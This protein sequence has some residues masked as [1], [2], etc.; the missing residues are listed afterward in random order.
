MPSIGRI[1]G[2]AF[3][4]TPRET[5]VLRRREAGESVEAIAVALRNSVFQVKQ[6]EAR[7]REKR[8][9]QDDTQV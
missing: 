4:L 8:A 1:V 9:C 2:S 5:E 6:W 3:R 7:A